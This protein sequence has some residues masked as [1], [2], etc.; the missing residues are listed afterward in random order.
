MA[1][2]WAQQMGWMKDGGREADL[3]FVVCGPFAK[4][5]EAVQ[6]DGGKA[7]FFMWDHTTSKGFWKADHPENE[8]ADLKR[9][10]EVVTPWPSW[11]IVARTETVGSKIGR[12]QLRT[13]MGVLDDSIEQMYRDEGELVEDIVENPELHYSEA[14][15]REW[16]SSVEYRRNGCA[17][18][19]ES[20]VART[21]GVVGAGRS[22]TTA[23]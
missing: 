19:D 13:I 8:G 23:V 22:G 9:L 6:E 3:K 11:S 12:E 21:V 17:G 16:L 15:A 1:K 2:V 5:R 14:D 18:V 10:G 7:D 20:M 4:L